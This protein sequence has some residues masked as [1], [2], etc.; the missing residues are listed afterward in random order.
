MSLKKIMMLDMIK[1][2]INTT[3]KKNKVVVGVVT[4]V[5]KKMVERKRMNLQKHQ[6]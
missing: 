6:K 3:R 2:L 5:E 1:P 4:Q